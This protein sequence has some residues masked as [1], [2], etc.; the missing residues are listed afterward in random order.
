MKYATYDTPFPGM[1][2][3]PRIG[4]GNVFRNEETL[5]KCVQPMCDGERHYWV[6]AK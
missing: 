6:V 2:R 1:D 3:L 4:C 5:F